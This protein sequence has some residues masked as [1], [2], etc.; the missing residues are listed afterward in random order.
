MNE[1]VNYIGRKSNLSISTWVYFWE[2]LEQVL[3]KIADTGY[4]NVE[5]WG[6]K[7][8]LDPRISPDIPLLKDLLN[9]LHLK[10]HSLH[11]PL[12]GCRYC[13]AR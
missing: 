3:R 4:T 5:I 8:H 10:V 9:G 12:F 7:A 13:F 1:H 6:D 11:T 2:P